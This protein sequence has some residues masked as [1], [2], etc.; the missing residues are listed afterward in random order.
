M[1]EEDWVKRIAAFNSSCDHSVDE[2]QKDELFCDILKDLF[3]VNIKEDVKI[4]MVCLFEQQMDI[5]LPEPAKAEYAFGCF[6]NVFCQT[7][8][9][10]NVILKSQILITMT[11]I[12]T[13]FNLKILSTDNFNKFITLLFGI[14]SIQ[15]PYLVVKT[16]CECLQIIEQ[17]YEG[18]TIDF[19]DVVYSS[20][21]NESSFVLS[22]Y[23]A[24]LGTIIENQKLRINNHDMKIGPERI[25]SKHLPDMLEKCLLLINDCTCYMSPT[26]L[27]QLLKKILPMLGKKKIAQSVFISLLTYC[28]QSFNILLIWLGMNIQ[29]WIKMKSS[30][31]SDVFKINLTILISMPQ[32]S[33]LHCSLLLSLLEPY[34]HIL[35]EDQRLDASNFYI[36]YI[37]PTAYMK[38]DILFQ[39][40][41]TTFFQLSSFPSP[42]NYQKNYSEILKVLFFHSH[43]I[44][45][46]KEKD[47]LFHALYNL[48]K[49][50]NNDMK[51]HITSFMEKYAVY[52]VEAVKNVIEFCEII[53][54]TSYESSCKLMKILTERFLKMEANYTEEILYY[55]LILF[56]KVVLLKEISP[57]AILKKLSELSLVFNRCKWDIGNMFLTICSNILITHSQPHIIYEVA[58][59]LWDI[60]NCFKNKQIQDRALFYYLIIGNVSPTLFSQTFISS[61]VNESF[62]EAETLQE[63]ATTISQEVLSAKRATTDFLSF[64][65]EENDDNTWISENMFKMPQ[66]SF[67]EYKKALMLEEY[68]RSIFHKFLIYF[69]EKSNQDLQDIFAV[70]IVFSTRDSYDKV[71]SACCPYLSKNNKKGEEV[72]VKF[73]PNKPQPVCFD[74]NASYIDAN[75]NC[76]TTQLDSIQLKFRHLFMPLPCIAAFQYSVKGLFDALWLDIEKNPSKT[77]FGE[78]IL[79]NN[80]IISVKY[81]CNLSSMILK[82]KLEQFITYEDATLINVGI[83]LPPRNHVL[84]KFEFGESCLVRIA[85]DDYTLLDEID[86]YLETLK[87]PE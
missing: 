40:R 39:Q 61:A 30:E 49:I 10:D 18:S 53:K 29:K 37:Q 81:M 17:C 87:L 85:T 55:Y 32:I 2:R 71:E 54:V 19:F 66:D 50:E 57:L 16:S 77:S 38:F 64:S 56:E 51:E 45:T 1:S 15:F 3:S 33:K 4:Q 23:M 48:Y 25:Q 31:N 80:N 8:N 67:E 75:S 42:N 20:A 24:L 12:C 28:G 69:N 9:T 70:E 84:F 43:Y 52:N 22:S 82:L 72:I 41:I 79:Q 34:L 60:Y 76:Y 73:T 44:L 21:K 35:P 62:E 14:K 65:L 27:V 59:L 7:D 11:V 68:R 86:D 46:S 36:P 83:H 6:L 74:V 78:K 47:V 63:V 13:S 58:S 5:L 26:G